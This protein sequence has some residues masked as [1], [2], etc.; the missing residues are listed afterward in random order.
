[1]LLMQYEHQLCAAEQN[2]KKVRHGPLFPLTIALPLTDVAM[3]ALRQWERAVEK[4]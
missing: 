4:W 1:M 2:R 3:D